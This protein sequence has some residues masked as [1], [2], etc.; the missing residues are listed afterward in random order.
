MALFLL[1]CLLCPAAVKRLFMWLKSAMVCSVTLTITEINCQ[2][3]LINWTSEVKMERFW[4]GFQILHGK[5]LQV[6]CFHA[7]FGG[8]KT[9][10]PNKHCACQKCNIRVI[11]NI[12]ISGIQSCCSSYPLWSL[13]NAVVVVLTHH[14]SIPLSTWISINS[15]RSGI[16]RICLEPY[17]KSTKSVWGG[18]KEMRG[19]GKNK[20]WNCISCNEETRK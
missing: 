18:L 11:W 10:K 3:R 9:N 17:N 16:T 8:E 5:L 13:L 20:C 4:V 19:R 1:E 15:R 14:L 12:A 6:L 7:C 2:V